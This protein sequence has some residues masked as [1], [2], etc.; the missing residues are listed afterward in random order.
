MGMFVHS[1]NEDE[2]CYSRPV[3]SHDED[4]KLMLSELR[5]M[6]DK[7]DQILAAQTRGQR[8]WNL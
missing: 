2:K 1:E 6:N 7:L 5:R 8:K 4:F 3:P